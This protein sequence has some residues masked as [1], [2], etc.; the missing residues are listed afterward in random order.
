VSPIAEIVGPDVPLYVQAVLLPFE[1]RI[2]Y[3]SLLAPYA[4]TF[5]GGI[6]R[7]LREAYRDAQERDGL[8]TSL[9]PALSQSGDG[10]RAAIRARNGKVLAAFRKEVP[11]SGMGPQTAEGHVRTIATFAEDSLLRRE[12]PRGLLALTS[13][14]LRAYLRADGVQANHVSVRRFLRFLDLTERVSPAEAAA[15]AAVLKEP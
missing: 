2:I 14:D 5:G 3:D 11:R 7:R 10:A 13:A 6:R 9:P 4:L 12:P 1:G 15:L 8:I